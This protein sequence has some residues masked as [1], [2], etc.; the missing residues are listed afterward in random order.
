MCLQSIDFNITVFANLGL[1]STTLIPL[2]IIDTSSK[3]LSDF[4]SAQDYNKIIGGCC[5]VDYSIVYCCLAIQPSYHHFPLH[6]SKLGHR[7]S[8]RTKLR[9]G[10]KLN[11]GNFEFVSK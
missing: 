6:S 2:L 11:N 1:F 3:Q 9:L 5:D 8:T 7:A 10:Y 4:S